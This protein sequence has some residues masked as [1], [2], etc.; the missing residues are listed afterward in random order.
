MTPEGKWIFNEK[1]DLSDI[2]KILLKYRIILPEFGKN[3]TVTINHQLYIF[4]MQN[5]LLNAVDFLKYISTFKIT[6]TSWVQ[7]SC[8]SEVWLYRTYAYIMNNNTIV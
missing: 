5:P 4:Y 3:F 8:S 1:E 2:L 6:T 7:S